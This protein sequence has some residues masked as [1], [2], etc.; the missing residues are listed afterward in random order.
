MATKQKCPF[1]HCDLLYS[2]V[3]TLQGV[4]PILKFY[5]MKSGTRKSLLK[6]DNEGTTVTN[7]NQFQENVEWCRILFDKE[8]VGIYQEVVAVV[9]KMNL[10]RKSLAT[11]DKER[12][13]DISSDPHMVENWLGHL[14][15]L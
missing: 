12:N 13:A 9:P 1:L 2:P 11:A 14:V 3:S 7:G 6:N 10:L 15:G 4:K 5:K 8:Y